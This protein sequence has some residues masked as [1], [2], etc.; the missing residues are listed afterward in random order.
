[1]KFLR[2][3]VLSAV[4][5]VALASG[6]VAGAKTIVN[7]PGRFQLELPDNYKVT[8]HGR[9]K[10]E[11]G[12]ELVAVSPKG[13]VKLF[14]KALPHGDPTADLGKHLLRWEENARLKGYFT[15]LT[16]VGPLTRR[17]STLTQLYSAQGTRTRTQHPYTV[18][19][20][21]NLDRRMRQ[22]YTFTLAAENNVFTKYRAK[23]LAL[24]S[25]FRPYDPAR[26]AGGIR[27]SSKRISL[28]G[29]LQRKPSGLV[30]GPVAR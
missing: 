25:R 6:A 26:V 16:R 23:L 30:T 21:V 15:Q 7:H 4:L 9:I 29:K 8:R 12:Y 28:R 20:G 18:Y 11:P 14:V 27:R 17:G 13:N 1:M 22:L 19:V 24:A 10:T 5:A 2:L 3:G